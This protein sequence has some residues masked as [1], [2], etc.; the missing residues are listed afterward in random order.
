MKILLAVDG[1]EGA[2]KATEYARNLAVQLNNAR[3]TIVHVVRPVD[4]RYISV[5]TGGPALGKVLE[6]LEAAARKKAREILTQTQGAFPDSVPTAVMVTVGDPA[7]EIVNVAKE[8]GADL[9]V[10]GSRGL[11]RI[12]GIVLGSVSDRVVHLAHCPVLVVR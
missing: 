3:V 2:Q 11:G 4:Y 9:I 8:T 10:M 1:S 5:E 6:E 7:A 12:Q